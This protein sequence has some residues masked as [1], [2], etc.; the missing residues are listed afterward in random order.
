[1]ADEERFR[2]GTTVQQEKRDA[3]PIPAAVAPDPKYRMR[4][5]MAVKAPFPLRFLASNY[6]QIAR[7]QNV[8]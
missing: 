8:I 6:L 2:T 3:L 5:A 4:R 1:L 7:V